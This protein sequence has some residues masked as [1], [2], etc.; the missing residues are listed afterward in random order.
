MTE[1]SGDA[2]AGQGPVRPVGV[3][4]SPRPP[5]ECVYTR[6][7]R[8]FGPARPLRCA[9]H[10]FS[11]AQLICE[12]SQGSDAVGFGLP[13]WAWRAP[14]VLGRSALGVSR[15]VG[16]ALPLF[17]E[18]LHDPARLKALGLDERPVPNLALVD[19]ASG[20]VI[21]FASG[22]IAEDQIVERIFVLTQSKP[23]D[24]Y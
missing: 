2:A 4:T 21:P 10:L 3:A 6:G 14:F 24:L 16:S 8:S 23:G 19:P 17:P 7:D 13:C 9:Q 20:E 15:D 22:A 5:L 11:R 1:R 18:P 12:W